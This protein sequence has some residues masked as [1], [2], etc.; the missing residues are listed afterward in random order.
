VTEIPIPRRPLFPTLRQPPTNRRQGVVTSIG[1]LNDSEGNTC[2]AVMLDYGG[3]AGPVRV[4]HPYYP[5]IGDTVELLEIGGDVY[6]LG[7]LAR[8]PDGAVAAFEADGSTDQSFT[9]AAGVQVLLGWALK[10]GFPPAARSGISQASGVVTVQRAGLYEIKADTYLVCSVATIMQGNFRIDRA[11]TVSGNVVTATTEI[12]RNY[13]FEKDGSV[14]TMSIGPVIGQVALAAGETFT[15][16]IDLQ[17]VPG[18]GTVVDSPVSYTRSLLVK[19]I[20]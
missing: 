19:Q 12:V 1:T 20:G 9:L 17:S 11:P 6:V 3:T 10:S 4:L 18:G 16:S 13:V 5:L 14:P 15:V 2:L 8:S 7:K